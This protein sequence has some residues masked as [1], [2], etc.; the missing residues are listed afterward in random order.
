MRILWDSVG[1]K[2]Q[3]EYQRDEVELLKSAGFKT[4]GPPS[5]G[6]YTSKAATLNKLRK[7]NPKSGLT[8]S[9]LALEKY[10]LI[11]EQESKKKELKKLFQKESKVAQNNSEKRPEYEKD[12]FVSFVVEQKDK[13]FVPTYI[14]PEPP[15][16]FCF[17]CGDFIYDYE[18]IDLCLWCQK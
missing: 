17:F 6:W 15:S 5:W 4:D 16:N 8:I 10:K 11:N 14:L 3:A 2:F 1:N 7:I 9:E 12:G 13:P 18:G